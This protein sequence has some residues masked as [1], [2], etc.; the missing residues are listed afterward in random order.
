MDQ[1]L[2]LIGG[3]LRDDNGAIYEK[4]V[5]LGG[6]KGHSKIGII[7]AAS[8]ENAVETGAFYVRQFEKYGVRQAYWIPIH[9]GNP[10]AAFDP[11]VQLKV[12]SYT[13]WSFASTHLL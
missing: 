11:L 4:M 12:N 8:L 3:N 1:S 5:T 9:L 2:L 6:G 13:C 10:Q 7:T